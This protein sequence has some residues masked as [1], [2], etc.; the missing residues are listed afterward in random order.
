MPVYIGKPSAEVVNCCMRVAG[1]TSKDEVLVVGDRLYTDI[2][3]GVNAGVETCVVYTGEAK[4]SDIAE[5]EWKP[6]YC[7][8][9]IRDL[10]EAFH[11][12]LG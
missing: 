3:C 7:F 10:Y 12:S 11:K 4:P 5:T 8:D 1:I 2:A 6:D 9:N